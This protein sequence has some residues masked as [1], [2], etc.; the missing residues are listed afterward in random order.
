MP[1][2][3][4]NND[5]LNEDWLHQLSKSPV[6][7]LSSIFTPLAEAAAKNKKTAS[8]SSVGR[9]FVNDLNALLTELKSSK[10]CWGMGSAV[11]YSMRCSCIIFGC[12]VPSVV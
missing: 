12:G 10:V 11:R 8:F 7:L 2:L 5:S 3:E 9:R 6:G 1:W 4:K